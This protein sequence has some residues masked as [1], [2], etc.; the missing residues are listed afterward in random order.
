MY[1]IDDHGKVIEAECGLDFL[2]GCHC[3]VVESSGGSNP[4]RGIKRRN[5][6]Y[7]E[8]LATIFR[9]LAGAGVPIVGIYLDS[10]KVRDI[11]LE[12]RLVELDR[13]Y[14]VN[15]ALVD[16]EEYRKDV[17]RYVATM[18]RSPTAKKGGNA[19]K[20]IRVCLDSRVTSN[21]LIKA[22]GG[23]APPVSA[24]D[25]A[26]N[27]KQTEREYI[28]K[29]RIGQGQFRAN[30]V[31]KYGGRCPI[32]GISSPELLVASHIKPW[33]SCTNAERLDPGNG[34]LLSALLDKLF[35]NGFISFE[36]GGR[37]QISPQLSAEEQ[38]RC[39]IEKSWS[40]KLTDRQRA[41][42]A[43]HRQVVFANT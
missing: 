36:V 23:S 31:E 39:G 15:L 10:S 29:A 26:P 4:A 35:D 20:R 7:N 33:K 11:P 21:Q 2:D 38:M 17:Q 40:I 5:P 43:F 6:D 27:L 34:V 16:A 30:L 42:M 8:V 12:Q 3:I 1:L 18:H 13:P 14:P 25:Y 24:S 22:S 41:Y 28:S 9:R 19:Q 37:V 32:T